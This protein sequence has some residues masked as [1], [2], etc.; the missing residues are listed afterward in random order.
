MLSPVIDYFNSITPLP[1]ELIDDIIKYAVIKEYKKNEF[2]LKAGKVSNYTSWIVKG[3]VRSYYIKDTEDITTKF[4][5]DGAP[6]TSVYSYYSRKPG[7][8]NIVA[9]EDTT[10]ASLHYDHMQYLYKTYPAFN[11]IG[12]VITEQYLYM[13]EIEAVSYTHLTLPTSDLV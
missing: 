5:W 9:L 12:R 2:I 13:L 4:L 1:P 10:L 3:L 8:E 11:V 7:N 6:I